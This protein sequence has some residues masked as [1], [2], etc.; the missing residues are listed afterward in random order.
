MEYTFAPD[1]AVA[2]LFPEAFEA[3]VNFLPPGER[4]GDLLAAYHR[5]LNDEDPEVSVPA[6]RAWNAYEETLMGLEDPDE[7]EAANDPVQDRKAV[8]V[9]RIECHY[10][11]NRL[12][13]EEGQILRPESMKRI[14]HIPGQ[15]GQCSSPFSFFLFSGCTIHSPLANAQSRTWQQ[16]SSSTVASTWS[17]HRRRRCYYTGPGRSRNYT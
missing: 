3:F 4:E 5:R 10:F 12:F 7:T 2:K 13:V 1:A 6:V 15:S 14:A 17:A 16:A 9:A 11:I 8:Q